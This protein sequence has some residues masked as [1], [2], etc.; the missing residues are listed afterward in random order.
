MVAI[1]AAESEEALEGS[2]FL[3]II[4]D[5][6]S[7]GETFIEPEEEGDDSII[8]FFEIRGGENAEMED[9]W[10]WR[11]SLSFMKFGVVGSS[12]VVENCARLL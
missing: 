9:N 11:R 10:W 12:V 6:K 3:L 8:L 4:A 1:S 5:I 7:S 2:I